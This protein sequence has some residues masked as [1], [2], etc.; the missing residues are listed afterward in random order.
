VYNTFALPNPTSNEVNI[1]SK[2]ESEN[3]TVVITDVSG[4]VIIS[5]NL[6]TSN[7]ISRLD[8]G[9]NNGIY[10]VIITNANKNTT[11]KKLVIAK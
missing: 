8:L 10:L 4:K 1:V 11:I 5:K 9:L 2:A 7:F 3:L 6:T